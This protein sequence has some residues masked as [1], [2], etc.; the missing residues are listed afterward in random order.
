MPLMP[1]RRTL[2]TLAY[3]GAAV[4]A[5][6]SV[7]ILERN[8][9]PPSGTLGSFRADAVSRVEIANPGERTVI[10]RGETRWTFE[11]PV[12]DWAD[13]AGMRAVVEGLCNLPIRES[14]AP[15]EIKDSVF[16]LS[17]S[18]AIGLRLDFREGPV[19]SERLLLGR[20]GPFENTVYARL[21]GHRERPGVHL[22]ETPLRPV[23]MAPGEQL[24]ERRLFTFPA[25]EVRSYSFRQGNLDV[26]L[27]R[28]PEEPRWFITRPIQCRANDDIAYSL[29]E[30]LASMRAETFIEDRALPAA[31]QINQA[32][33]SFALR[34]KKGDAVQLTLEPKV[35]KDRETMLAHLTGRTTVLEIADNF[36]SRLPRS[37]EQ[38]RFPNLV[39]FN[40][41]AVARILIESREDPDVQLVSDGRRWNL[42]SGGQSRPA[43]EER[44]QRM[45]EALLAEPVVD[46]RS[47]SLAGLER[48]GLDRPDV[49]VSIVTSSVDATAY[50]AYQR[51]LAQA[52]LEGRDPS[53]VTA[54]QV[55]VAQ[56]QLAFRSGQDGILNVNLA[57]SPFVYGVDP[58][59]LSSSIPTHPLKWRDSQILGFSLF[60][61]RAIEIEESGAPELKLAYDYLQNQWGASLGG[62][63]VDAQVD[64]RRA[65][66]LASTLG[67]LTARD[68]LSSRA[69]ALDALRRPSCVIKL[70]TA[71]RPG[72][73]ETERILHLAPAVVGADVEFYFGQFEGDPD[74]FVLDAGT[75]GRII[76]PVIK[77]PLQ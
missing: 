39:E 71:P 43:N 28:D 32:A 61:V 30:E 58:A 36:T 14:I 37:L 5:A 45:L 41:D 10:Q 38:F 1:G 54:P 76:A 6:V 22:V 75:Y 11:R 16:G 27:T 55:K 25:T 44:L 68:F 56:F 19:K 73:P 69:A 20:A 65:E 29:L 3:V 64:S 46:F 15:G 2:V 18:K 70:R 72:D 47:N 4:L 9:P 31:A 77:L 53:S 60:E 57:G 67:N 48:Y 59:L 74:V 17:S 35:A 21:E 40:K 50:D 8:Q 42:V 63:P 7:A 13:Q 52:R 51:D 24:R 23:V 34:P 26:E 12:K 62:V 66:L 49:R 33:A